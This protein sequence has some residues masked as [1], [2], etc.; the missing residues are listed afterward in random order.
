MLA[1]FAFTEECIVDPSVLIELDD[2]GRLDGEPEIVNALLN[3]FYTATPKRLE[4]LVAA[5]MQRDVK[6]MR[7]I[8]HSL[9]SACGY[10]GV[11][12]MQAMCSMLESMCREGKT[13]GAERLVQSIAV[14]FELVKVELEKT[15]G[16]IKCAIKT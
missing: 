11:K 12:R 15:K 6:S 14:E 13:A 16:E 1:D 2:Y 8:A 4:L 3:I 9:K 5:T 7:L 10:L